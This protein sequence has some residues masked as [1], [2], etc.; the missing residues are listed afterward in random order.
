MAAQHGFRASVAAPLK[1]EG[2]A[3]GA[4][5]L[6]KAEPGAFTPQQI[7]LLETFAAQAVIA[8]ENVR[9]FTELSDALEQQ[10]A[11]ADILGV[12]SRS[13]TDVQPV[14]E[15]VT[16][17]ALRFCGAPDAIVLLRDGD[18]NVVV[19]HEGTL[20]ATLG[21]RRPLAAGNFSGQAIRE[22]RTLQI[23]D[24]DALDPAVHAGVLALARQHKWRASAAAPMMH[25]GNAIG[26]V[27]L[28]KPEP[29]LLS[30]RQIALLETFAA[31]A[32]IA[33]ENVRLFT[34]LRKSLEQQTASAEI[35]EAI[36]QSPTDVEPVLKA[37]VGAARRFAV[38][39]LQKRSSSRLPRR[40]LRDLAIADRRAAG[41][42]LR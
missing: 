35:L 32:V 37:V 12:I 3:I 28:R 17:A 40:I 30:P 24:V 11:T 13:P 16:R 38:H 22:G 21:L 31:Q 26:C 25:G 36:S 23:A 9:L 41:A 20:T 33:I 42:R 18:D 1:R 4:V 27:V 5:A 14:L 34:E 7:E 10:T 2:A 8:I 19:A 39:E 6:R 29:G 15:A